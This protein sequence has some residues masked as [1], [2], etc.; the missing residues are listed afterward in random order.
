VKCHPTV[1]ACEARVNR[2]GQVGPLRAAEAV[3]RPAGCASRPRLQSEPGNLAATALA[4]S[5]HSCILSA[6][7]TLVILIYL[8]SCFCRVMKWRCGACWPLSVAWLYLRVLTRCLRQL[9]RWL[10]PLEGAW[11]PWRLGTRESAMP[12]VKTKRNVGCSQPMLMRTDLE[13]HDME[14]H[15]M[16]NALLRPVS[17]STQ[18][19][20]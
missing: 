18:G 8:A 2:A 16:S 12:M 13:F 6:G 5:L 3:G 15:N 4:I 7:W 1:F 11:T 19:N 20:L 17:C 9:R 10:T 14:S